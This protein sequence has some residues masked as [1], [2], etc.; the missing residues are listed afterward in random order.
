MPTIMKINV[1]QSDQTLVSAVF[2]PRHKDSL[3]LN[4]FI[5]PKT[6]NYTLKHNDFLTKELL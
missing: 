1:R 3:D 6:N 2:V 5:Y 4:H